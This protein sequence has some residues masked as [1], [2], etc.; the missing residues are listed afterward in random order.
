MMVIEIV[1]GWVFGLMG[2]VGGLVITKWAVGLLRETSSVL[3]DGSEDQSILESIR[4]KIEVD[5][6]N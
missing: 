2:I 3:L 5:G 1:T 4:L 6:D